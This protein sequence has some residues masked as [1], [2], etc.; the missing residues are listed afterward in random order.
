MNNTNMSDLSKLIL[1]SSLADVPHAILGL[2]ESEMIG[3]LVEPNKDIRSIKK[4]LGEFTGNKVD[5]E[6]NY[7]KAY[8]E[9]GQSFLEMV[10]DKKM[11]LGDFK[12]EEIDQ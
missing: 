9:S 6:L 1:V 7:Y 8:Y 5:V 2:S 4:S 12:E 10:A 3:Y 11:T